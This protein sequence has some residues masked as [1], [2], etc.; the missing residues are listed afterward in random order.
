MILPWP[1]Q[2]ATESAE[3]RVALA[4]CRVSRTMSA[5]PPQPFPV[6]HWSLVRRAG[7]PDPQARQEALATLLQRYLPA[8]RSYLCQL[9]GLREEQADELL[10]AFVADKLLG[11]QLLAR[12]DASRGRFRTFLL[13]SLRHFDVGRHR[14][15]LVR[16]AEPLPL[17]EVATATPSPAAV[18]E[19]EW[20]RALLKEIAKDCP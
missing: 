19:V 6:T 8:L 9:R 20:A 7:L 3:F 12:A 2:L 13:T 17:E 10:Q 1:V 11:Q 15:A 5:T 14:A 16:A 18:V 4:W